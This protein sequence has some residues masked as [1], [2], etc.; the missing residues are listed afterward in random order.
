MDEIGNWKMAMIKTIMNIPAKM[1][2]VLF[3]GIICGGIASAMES[4]T[5]SLPAYW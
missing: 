1:D 3:V 2:P 4:V 5:D